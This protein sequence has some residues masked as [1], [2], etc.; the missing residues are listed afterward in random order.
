MKQIL[1]FA[2]VHFHHTTLDDLLE[3][4]HEIEGLAF[5]LKAQ[6][7]LD[8]I[9][10][11]G[12]LTTDRGIIDNATAVA[13]RSFINRLAKFAP[14]YIVAGNHDLTFKDGQP[15][16]LRAI[17]ADSAGVV[18][19][20][21]YVLDYP[22]VIGRTGYTLSF[23]PY[24]SPATFHA[25]TGESDL[26]QISAALEDV[27]RGLV[28]KAAEH[29]GVPLAVF[30]GTVEGGRSG[31]E[32]SPAMATRGR[33]IVLPV[34]ALHGFRATLCGHLHH[35]QEIQTPTG[36]AVYPGCV[37]PLTFGERSIEPSAL[38]WTIDG[39]EIGRAHV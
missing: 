16:N 6:G 10:I 26:T 20:N 15:N 23:L 5:N 18:L 33:D 24:P 13:D 38:V 14:V 35:P 19:S 21:V 31:N 17:L 27:C 12:D 29:G 8:A 39:E 32:S 4:C 36:P 37:T 3:P 11:A 1:H 28:T 25:M 2:D 30:H 9:V 34:A 7:G 22:E